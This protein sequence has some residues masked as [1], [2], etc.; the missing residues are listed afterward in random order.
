MTNTTAKTVAKQTGANDM[1]KEHDSQ[2]KCEVGQELVQA[3]LFIWLWGSAKS[4]K[5]AGVLCGSFLKCRGEVVTA[6]NG[7]LKSRGGRAEMRS[8]AE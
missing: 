4:L 8:G 5:G 6:D 3:F 1:N 7:A 2:R